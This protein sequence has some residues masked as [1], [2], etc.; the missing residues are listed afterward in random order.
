MRIQDIPLLVLGI[1]APAAATLGQQADEV[2]AV[3]VATAF[4]RDS[5]AKGRIVIDPALYRGTIGITTPVADAAA[6]Q[7]GAERGRFG[8]LAQCPVD[9]PTGQLWN[10]T[11]PK[12]VTVITFGKPKF[13]GAGATVT[14][15][16]VQSTSPGA[17]TTTEMRLELARVS[18]GRWA[19]QRRRTVGAS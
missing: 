12:G 6:A 11:L 5:I 9:A 15:V 13:A 17:M 2:G 7:S 4:V 16:V 1:A 14:L 18:D 3:R 10:C 19:L 8:D